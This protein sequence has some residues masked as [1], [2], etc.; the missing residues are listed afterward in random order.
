MQHVTHAAIRLDELMGTVAGPGRGGTALFVG[1]V[2][3]GP[4]DG[5]VARIEYSAYEEMLEEEFA[6]ILCAARERWPGARVAAQH[7]L[8]TVPTG[9]ASIAVVA[10]AA[11]RAAAFEVCRH[12]VEAAKDQLPVWKREVLEDGEARWHD[13]SGRLTPSESG[14]PESR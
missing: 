3:R 10:A 4:E 14:G 7:R 6:R 11:H 8:G 9:E 1:T 13:N 12:V 2:R 5:P